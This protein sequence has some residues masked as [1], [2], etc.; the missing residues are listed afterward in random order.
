MNLR[1]QLIK[2]RVDSVAGQ[3]KITVDEAFMRL[4]HSLVT[5]KSVL[6]FEPN[7]IVD[8]GQDKQMDVISIEEGADCVPGDRPRPRGRS[9]LVASV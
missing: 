6:A 5:F 7:D 1:Q 3:L 8:G 4:A 9:D 2:D